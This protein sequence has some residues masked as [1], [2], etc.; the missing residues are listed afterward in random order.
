[1]YVDWPVVFA[2]FKAILD[3]IA[4]ASWPIAFGAVAYGFR[5]PISKLLG[6]IKTV[7]GWGASMDISPAQ[8]M[9]ALQQDGSETPAL[10]ATITHDTMPPTDPV[11]DVMDR[12]LLESLDA[13]IGVDDRLKLI[14]AVRQRSISEANRLHE[15]HYRLMFG[16]Q[17][18]ALVTLNQ[19]GAAPVAIFEKFYDEQVRPDPA[20]GAI[21]DGR[22]FEQWGAF[23]VDAA[24]AEIVH[25]SNPPTVRITPF[26][27]QFCAWLGHTGASQA[28]LG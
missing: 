25:G 18:K 7:S 14:W 1:M 2:G 26:G 24:Y 5:S 11:F 15:F 9:I 4:S 3:P 19:T 13:I 23:I 22:S 6:R 12:N 16:S 21:H 28:K 10:P 17:I 8:E 27:R 20:N